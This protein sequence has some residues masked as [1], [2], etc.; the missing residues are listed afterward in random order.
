MVGAVGTDECRGIRHEACLQIET[1]ARIKR[2]PELV[3]NG[4]GRVGWVL[5]AGADDDGIG[6]GII[7]TRDIVPK[8]RFSLSIIRRVAAGPISG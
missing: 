5:S 6:V 8:R 7:S 2:M 4:I 1:E 3:K